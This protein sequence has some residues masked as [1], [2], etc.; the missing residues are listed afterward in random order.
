MELVEQSTTDNEFSS[1]SRYS[2]ITPVKDEA[3]YIEKTIAS[4]IAQTIKPQ[5]WVIV[6][7]GSSDGTEAIVARWVDE[8][9]WIRLVNRSDRG[10]RQRGKG[11]IEAFNVGYAALSKPFEY[12]VKLDGDV[13]FQ[14]DYFESLLNE[15]DSD[16]QLGIAGG[17]VYEQPD[18]ETWILHT[19]Q[20]HVRGATKVYRRT[21][22]EEIGGL[23]P[24]MGWDGIDEWKALSQGWKVISFQEYPLY[25]YR[26][27]GAATGFVKSFYEQGN[28]AY[29]MGYHPLYI[30]A[31][32]LRRMADRPYVIGGLAM[33][34]G[35]VVGFIRQDDK[36]ADK[37]V[38]N[39][40]RQTQ[41]RKL[42]GLLVGKPVH[43]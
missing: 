26:F 10:T 5:E 6:N 7:D 41:M 25:H 16:P 8:H 36:L 28:G 17:G 38:V 22:F 35:Y 2:V 37:S 31:R 19:T 27:T 12:I 1:A 18:G 9:P 29:R 39:F 40:I 23:A 20:D 14:E 33:L 43:E 42:F 3:K 21:C 24:S 32:S 15:F 34:S 13:S 11:V 4:M 30:I